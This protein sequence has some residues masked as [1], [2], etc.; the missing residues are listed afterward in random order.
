MNPRTSVAGT[1]APAPFRALRAT[2]ATN[3]VLVAY[4]VYM[5]CLTATVVL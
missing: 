5:V 3:P 2:W 4:I 1:G